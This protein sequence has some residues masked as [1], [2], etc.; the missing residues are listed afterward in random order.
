MDGFIVG[1]AIKNYYSSFIRIK[2]FIA[3]SGINVQRKKQLCVYV[4]PI[5]IYIFIAQILYTNVYIFH[6]FLYLK[7]W[8]WFFFK[9]IIYLFDTLC[10][11]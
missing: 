2:L 3:Y 6:L 7:P 5:M 9:G 10:N 11:L 1:F 8:S 4:S